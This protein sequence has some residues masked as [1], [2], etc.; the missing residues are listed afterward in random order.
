MKMPEFT[1]EA[2]LYRT[3]GRYRVSNG[4]LVQGAPTQ[5]V[6]LALGTTGEERCSNCL[7]KCANALGA[8]YAAAVAGADIFFPPP[9]VP[10][11]PWRTERG[12]GEKYC[13][14]PSPP[15]LAHSF[16]FGH[17]CYPH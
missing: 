14:S 9:L 5:P 13:L 11:A 4:G 12:G 7:T 15:D 6:V 1:A 10:L 3:R 17:A 16:P 2:S 8:C